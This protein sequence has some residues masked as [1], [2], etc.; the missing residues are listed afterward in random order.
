MKQPKIK[1]STVSMNLRC[2]RYAGIA[3][4]RN[5]EW[6]VANY[7]HIWQNIKLVVNE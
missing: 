3:S 7:S 6:K 5:A 1:Q 2:T 4:N